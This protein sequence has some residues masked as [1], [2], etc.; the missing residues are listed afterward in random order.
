M[1]EDNFTKLKSSA[2]KLAGVLAVAFL[3][4]TYGEYFKD[5]YETFGRIFYM[6]GGTYLTANLMSTPIQDFQKA[7]T[8]YLPRIFR[9]DRKLDDC[10]HKYNRLRP[11]ITRPDTIKKLEEY[12]RE[13]EVYLASSISQEV[14]VFDAYIEKINYILTLHEPMPKTT[15]DIAVVIKKFDDMVVENKDELISKILV[16]F[17]LKLNG[18]SN[19]PLTPVYLLGSSGVGKTFFVH[20]M[21]EILNI[22]II[23]STIGKKYNCQT[24]SCEKFDDQMVHMYTK[25]LYTAIK[26]KKTRTFIMFVDEFDKKIERTSHML[27]YINCNNNE[28]YDNYLNIQTDIGDILFI[29]AGNKRISQVHKCHLPLENRFVTITFPKL[30]QETKTSI[31]YKALEIPQTEGI[32]TLIANDKFHGIRQLLMKINIYRASIMGKQFFKGT[33]WENVIRKQLLDDDDSDDTASVSVSEEEEAESKTNT[34]IRTRT[35]SKSPAPK[36]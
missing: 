23:S 6:L 24:H 28:I 1:N 30:S 35:R 22:P 16:P 10:I 13:A 31:I 8:P 27:E 2:I 21:A 34:K 18:E 11:Y 26:T 17:I 36:R 7:L 12:F 3:I 15:I 29:T 25:A 9:S 4:E 14:L 19:I 32:D 20:K 5:L 33:S